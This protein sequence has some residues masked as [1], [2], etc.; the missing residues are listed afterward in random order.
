[1][2]GMRNLKSALRPETIGADKDFKD[3]RAFKD[4]SDGGD[5]RECCDVGDMGMMENVGAMGDMG[6]MGAPRDVEVPVMDEM[7][8]MWKRWELWHGRARY[9]NLDT[10]RALSADIFE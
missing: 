7:R 6:M 9:E 5:R 4:F 8:A 2:G 3:L 1:M 10:L